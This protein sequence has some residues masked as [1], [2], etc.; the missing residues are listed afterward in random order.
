MNVLVTG[1]AGYIGSHVCK[2]AAV[3]GWNPVVVDNLSTGFR[4]LVKWGDFFEA[5]VRDNVTL[6]VLVKKIKPGAVVH[7]AASAYVGESIKAPLD[8]YANN[9]T[10]MQSLLKACVENDVNH[11]VFSS[12]CAVYGLPERC[13]ISEEMPT[14]P[15][16]PY[17]E[18][19]LA[20]ER[21]LHWCEQAHGIKW[22]GLRYFNAAGADPDTEIGEMH[23]PETHLI[24][25]A[26]QCLSGKREFVEIFGDDYPT[27]DGS[28]VR[29]YVHV[30][31]LADAH[32]LAVKYLRDGAAVP[33]ALNLGTGSGRSIFEIVDTIRDVT[34]L[35]LNT[36]ISARRTGDPP[37]LYATAVAAKKCL[38]WTPRF[39]DIR[40]IINTAWAWENKT[41]RDRE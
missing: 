9:L 39:S 24:P 41:G 4:Q 18:T 22:L 35:A 17:G 29:D 34:G 36:R 13:P 20:C 11:F 31:D 32:V 26:L 37:E 16:N 12:S 30:S 23:E 2:A 6:S 28:A 8:Y 15:I 25:S 5:D 14:K 27:R 19:K 1:G 38:S 10:G 3:N 33:A 40:D 21:L 7:L